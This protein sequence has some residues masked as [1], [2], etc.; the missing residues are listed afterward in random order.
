MYA[1]QEQQRPANAQPVSVEPRALF[2]DG[3]LP[4]VD[5]QFFAAEAVQRPAPRRFEPEVHSYLPPA[6]VEASPPCEDDLTWEIDTEMHPMVRDCEKAFIRGCLEMLVNL[7]RK[8]GGVSRWHASSVGGPDLD[9][10]D[11]ARM[12]FEQL[13]KDNCRNGAEDLFVQKGST[14]S[15]GSKKVVKV[16]FQCQDFDARV[17]VCWNWDVLLEPAE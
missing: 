16:D 12:C 6:V 8:A 7:V 11:R 4:V 3:H 17:S 2:E 9:P 1:A 14:L 15:L 5:T 10:Q 13:L